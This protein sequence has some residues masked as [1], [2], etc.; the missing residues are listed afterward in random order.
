MV[1]A[2]ADKLGDGDLVRFYVFGLINRRNKFGKLD[3]RLTLG[4]AKRVKL[5]FS[6]ARP[7]V[8][9]GVEFESKRILAALLNMTLHD[10]NPVNFRFP[11]FAPAFV[12]RAV[13]PSAARTVIGPGSFSP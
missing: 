12:K 4:P 3:L 9:A 7:F 1:D 5:C 2:R 6:L 10:L 11:F 13:M 8:T